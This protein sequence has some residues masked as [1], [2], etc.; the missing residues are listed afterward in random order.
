MHGFM[1]GFMHGRLAG[2]GLGCRCASFV[3]FDFHL[4]LAQALGRRSRDAWV[5]GWLRA[6]QHAA[7][8]VLNVSALYSFEFDKSPTL[9]CKMCAPSLAGLGFYGICCKFHVTPLKTTLNPNTL[10]P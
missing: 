2:C 1:H 3:S 9:L 10:K 4:T 5:A 7:V 8:R 6:W